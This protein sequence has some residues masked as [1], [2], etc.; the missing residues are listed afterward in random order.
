MFCIIINTE[1]LHCSS[2]K[3][4]PAADSTLETKKGKKRKLDDSLA[5]GKGKKVKK[6]EPL[7]EVQDFVFSETSAAAADET[8]SPGLLHMSLPNQMCLENLSLVSSPLSSP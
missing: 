5:E 3:Y 7:E 6:E 2:V 4:N 8:K 1:F